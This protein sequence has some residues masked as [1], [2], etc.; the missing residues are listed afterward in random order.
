MAKDKTPDTTMPDDTPPA[1]TPTPP[2]RPSWNVGN[3][4]WGLLFVLG[5]GLFLLQ[6]F[7]VINLDLSA[8]WR[9]WPLLIIAAGA[10]ILSV[11]SRWA[12]ASVIILV[13][14]MIG[15]IAAS[16]LGYVRPGLSDVSTQ[17]VDVAQTDQRVQS[18]NVTV[19]SGAG[20][21][22]IASAEQS[23]PVK[24]ELESNITR[25]QQTSTQDG[26]RQRINIST[27]GDGNWWAGHYRNDLSVSL[28]R[29]LPTNLTIDAGAAQIRGDLEA[30]MLDTLR[31]N[32]GAS[33]IDLTL[34]AKG[35]QTDVSFDVGVSSIVLRVPKDSGISLTLESG[36]SGSD[37]PGL[38]QKSDRYYES[39]NYDSAQH[40]INI[41]GKMGMSH[42]TLSYY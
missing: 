21:L 9:L 6:S 33:D 4:F 26:S 12:A 32:S 35:D 8:L 38:Q 7:D 5:G 1:A 27:E 39:D 36:M 40:Q 3:I 41:S 2:P 24:A 30:V 16:L 13:I 20:T 23:P 10:S 19:K 17:N 29:S 37:I 31:V 14:A 25:L 28:T 18:L 34:G 15:F 42:F 22:T 11:R